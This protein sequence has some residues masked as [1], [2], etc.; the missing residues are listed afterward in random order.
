MKIP[1]DSPQTRAARCIITAV[2]NAAP[3][4]VGFD[5]AVLVH[6]RDLDRQQLLE[7][8]GQLLWT[9]KGL[10]SWRRVPAGRITATRC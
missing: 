8:L 4:G 1:I 5:G 7:V 9:A 3:E 10:V 2:R 6:T